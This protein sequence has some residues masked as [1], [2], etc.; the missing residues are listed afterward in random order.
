MKCDG[1]ISWHFFKFYKNEICSEGSLRFWLH[2]NVSND[3]LSNDIVSND[4]VSNDIVSNDIVS[5][6]IVSNDIVPNDVVCPMT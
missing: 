3:I 4:I 1:A 5:N 2:A 6:D